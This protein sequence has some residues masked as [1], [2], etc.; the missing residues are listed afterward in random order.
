MLSDIV[1]DALLAFLNMLSPGIQAQRVEASQAFNL[2]VQVI[3][4]GN[5]IHAITPDSLISLHNS[6][7]LSPRVK[8]PSSF[9]QVWRLF[10]CPGSYHIPLSAAIDRTHEKV[11]FS[12]VK[13]TIFF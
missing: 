3:N 12:F 2:M 7:S 11:D 5:A 13:S 4:D 10:S 8:I 9:L 1:V 6:S